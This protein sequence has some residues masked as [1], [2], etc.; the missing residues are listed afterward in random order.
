MMKI[1]RANF[2][3]TV[4]AGALAPLARPPLAQRPTLGIDAAAKTVTVGAFTPVTGPVPFY[5]ILTRAADAFFRHLNESGGIRG[6]QV[7]YATMDDGY[8]PSR[9]VAVT[10]RLVEEQGIFALVA[11]VGTSTNVAAIP[12]AREQG[13]PIIGPIGGA[14]AFFTERHVFPLLPTT[15]GPRHQMS[16]TRWTA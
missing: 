3:A 1:T 14:S 8:E 4:A 6:W 5:A 13:L 16:S 11:A 7:R 9:S 12:Y 2:L 10:R 15:A